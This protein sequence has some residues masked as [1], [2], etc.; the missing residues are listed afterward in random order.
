MYKSNT[1]KIVATIEARMTSTR[2]PGKVLMPLAG[3][4]ALERMVERVKRSKYIDY[5]VIAT[6]VNVADSPIVELADKLNVNCFRG[7]EMDVLGRVLGAAQSVNADIIVELTGDCPLMD[8]RVVDRGIEEFLENTSDLACNV[9]KRTF[10]DGFDVQVFPTKILAGVATTTDDKLDRE[11]VSRYIY[12]HPEK[13]KIHN[14]EPTEENCWP[15]LRVTLDEQEDYDLI[16]KIF[17]I[18]LK[19]NEDFTMEDVINLCKN[20]R[21]LVKINKHVKAKEI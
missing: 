21:D 15:D 7:S 20:N 19:S 6:T 18:L 5:I 8:W 16:N 1:K 3:K 2:L 12:H 13:Y 11:H 17:E 9:A 4:P 10:P 14:W